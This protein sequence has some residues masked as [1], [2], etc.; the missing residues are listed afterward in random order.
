MSEREGFRDFEII[1]EER[2]VPEERGGLGGETTVRI[3]DGISTIIRVPFC[4]VCGKMLENNFVICSLCGAKVCYECAIWYPRDRVYSCPYC[5]ED[6]LEIS[7]KD[8]K[9]LLSIYHAV[10][11]IPSIS[12][13]S[14]MSTTEIK[15]SLNDL[16]LRGYIT[17]KTFFRRSR[18]TDE[19]LYIL[20]LA[21]RL[22]GNDVDVLSLKIKLR[23]R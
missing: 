19:G 14:G 13:A 1:R 18:L 7:K 21:D 17:K 11:G 4:D 23:W 3:G 5:L 10:C 2:R 20:D 12:E 6:R 16:L 15:K 22:W 8:Y 9:V